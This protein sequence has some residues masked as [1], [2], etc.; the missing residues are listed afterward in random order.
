MNANRRIQGPESPNNLEAKGGA[1]AATA[2]VEPRLYADFANWLDRDLARLEA[3][4]RDW[5]TAGYGQWRRSNGTG[6]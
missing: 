5:A 6:R 2:T 3:L 4:Y 1:V